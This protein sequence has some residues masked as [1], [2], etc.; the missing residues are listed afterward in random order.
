MITKIKAAYVVGFDGVGHEI[1]TNGEVVY[2][3]D[4]ISMLENIT[5]KRWTGQRIWVTRL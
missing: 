5:K 1:I 4:T 2:E 3:N